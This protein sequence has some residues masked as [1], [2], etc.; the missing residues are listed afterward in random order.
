MDVWRNIIKLNTQALPQRQIYRLTGKSISALNRIIQAYR[1][2]DGRLKDAAPSGRNRCTSEEPD[3]LIVAAA[4]ADPFQS[5]HQIKKALNL[6]AKS[7]RC[8]LPLALT[9]E[10][11]LLGERR[12]FVYAFDESFHAAYKLRFAWTAHSRDIDSGKCQPL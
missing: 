2:E 10:W 5:A 8:Q 3:L 12:D 9:R 11:K 6:Q 1:D 7:G 4:L